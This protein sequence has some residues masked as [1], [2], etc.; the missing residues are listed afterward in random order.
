MSRS[1]GTRE[2]TQ[3]FANARPYS[4]SPVVQPSAAAQPAPKRTD[5]MYDQLEAQHDEQFSA[6]SGK[7]NM[8]KDITSRIGTEVKDSTTLLGSLEDRFDG[9]RTSVKSTMNRM[10]AAADRSGVSWRSWLALAGIIIFCFW[11]VTFF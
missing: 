11:L 8:L 7:I 5:A 1:T 9:A 4:P 10:I 3:L 6:L 2:R